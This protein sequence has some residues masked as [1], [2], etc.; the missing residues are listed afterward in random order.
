[1]DLNIRGSLLFPPTR[2]RDECLDV[3]HEQKLIT[4]GGNESVVY[5]THYSRLLYTFSQTWAI[6][7]MVKSDYFTRI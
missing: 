5:N 7:W 2:E 1:M 6:R 4:K 3:I